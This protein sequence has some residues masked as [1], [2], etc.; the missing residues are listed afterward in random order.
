MTL[1]PVRAGQKVHQDVLDRLECAMAETRCRQ[2]RLA[3]LLVHLPRFR[4]V[5]LSVGYDASERLMA[6]I[7]ANLPGLL[8]SEDFVARLWGHDFVAVLPSMS[9]SAQAELAA[10]RIV[11][12]FEEPCMVDGQ[13]MF[14]PAQ[15]GGAFYPD[16]GETA[17]AL[18]QCAEHA[19]IHALDAGQDV[20]FYNKPREPL[21]VTDGE[22]R[23]VVLNNR[24]ILYLQPQVE[25]ATGALASAEALARWPR[26]G[27]NVSPVAFV[28]QAERCGLIM[29]LTRWSLNAALRASSESKDSG[30]SL[31]VAVNLSPCVIQERGLVEHILDALNIWGVPSDHLTVEVTE[32]ALMDDPVLCTRVLARLGDAGVRVA[33][34]DFGVGY[35]SFA[36]LKRFVANELKIDKTFMAGL[37]DHDKT[38]RLVDAMIDLGHR[39]GM[40]V[41]AEGVES[42]EVLDKLGELGCDY[43]QGYLTGAPEPAEYFLQRSP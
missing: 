4:N 17:E 6:G 20:I 42:Q 38:L 41:V 28:P 39:L 43:A 31:P 30:R 19:L 16:D 5:H 37:L 3:V 11:N 1:S 8:R 34:D 23:D 21:E 14:V 32:N 7:E 35:S 29:N 10:H 40:S 2:R 22:L 33:I 18:L 15:V 9:N 26:D 13:I 27:R 24:L 36:Y 25:I 12:R